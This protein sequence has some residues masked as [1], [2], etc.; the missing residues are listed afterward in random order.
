MVWV[1]CEMTGLDPNKDKI[2]EIAVL[3]T[4]GNL[5]LVDEGIEFIIR[6]DKAS[7]D[8]MDEWCTK[9]HGQVRLL[10]PSV[11][12]LQDSFRDT[13]PVGSHTSVSRFYSHSRRSRQS[14]S[15]LHKEM[16]TFKT[17]RHPC[18]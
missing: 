17:H 18:W 11:K 7:L 13:L 3:I 14:R 1:D 9:Q 6:T 10:S 8:G 2:L 16:G 15:R 5:D 12:P 4:N